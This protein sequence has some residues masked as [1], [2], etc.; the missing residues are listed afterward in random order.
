MMSSLVTVSPCGLAAWEPVDQRAPDALG[1]EEHEGHEDEADDERPALGEDGEPVAQHEIGAGAH[2]GAEKGAGTA[3]QR[4]DH[5]LPRGDPVERLHRYHGE[6]KGVEPAGQAREEGGED[7]GQVLHAVDVVAAGGGAVTVFAD[8]LEHGAEGRIEDALE[9]GHGQPHDDE[10]EVVESERAFEVEL[11]PEELD[12]EEREAT[13]A[14]AAPRH[15]GQEEG[16]A[17]EELG[18]GQGESGEVEAAP[19][20]TEKAGGR[21]AQ[22]GEGRP[23]REREPDRADLELGEGEAGAVGAEAVVGG[24]AE[25]EQARVAVEQV[26][27]EGEET[28]DQHLRGEGLVGHEERKHGE[29]DAEG[30]DLVAAHEGRERGQGHSARPASPTM[31]LGRTRR[32]RAITTNTMISASLGA[33]S[34]V[35]PTTCPMRIPATTAPSRLPMPPTTMTTKDSMTMVTPIAA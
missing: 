7:K 19:A 32:T 30:D 34:V 5:H 28:E 10:R 13:Q 17:V 22:H 14:V 12:G 1:Q 33:K 25:G 18:E 15:V 29:E 20:Q 11:P 8:G 31:P 35:M 26:E 2:E 16:D 3:E 23:G 6:A 21:A 24:V 4:H 27:A 9:R